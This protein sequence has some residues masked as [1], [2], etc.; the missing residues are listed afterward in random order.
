MP[1]IE[2]SRILKRLSRITP[3][4]LA[5]PRQLALPALY[6]S[7]AVVG[8]IA[9]ALATQPLWDTKHHKW[10]VGRVGGGKSPLELS[11]TAQSSSLVRSGKAYQPSLRINCVGGRPNVIM[12]PLR[13][14][15]CLGDCSKSGG[16]MAF[17]EEFMTNPN[18]PGTVYQ[19]QAKDPSP[20]YADDTLSNP[21]EALIPTPVS[22]IGLGQSG[23]WW[24]APN[25]DRAVRFK[26]AEDSPIT[27]AQYY[28][29]RNFIERLGA[30]KVFKVVA[31][32]EAEFDTHDLAPKLAQLWAVC[33]M[34]TAPAPPPQPYQPPAEQPPSAPPSDSTGLPAIIPH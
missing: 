30:S 25:G 22:P 7:A 34:P 11:I 32:G 3:A 10:E 9:L 28:Q 1:S 20:L 16:T 33:P 23:S 13:Y 8:T 12:T 14:D 17:F 6:A 29:A 21:P 2:P 24:I 15:Y 5:I 27:P 31:S 18:R 4:D 19:A 26:Y